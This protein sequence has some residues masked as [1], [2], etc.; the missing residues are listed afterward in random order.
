MNFRRER[1]PDQQHDI[2]ALQ[3]MNDQLLAKQAEAVRLKQLRVQR[4]L[5]KLAAIATDRRDGAPLIDESIHDFNLQRLPQ[6]RRHSAGYIRTARFTDGVLLRATTDN[7]FSDSLHTLVY[8]DGSSL[9]TYSREAINVDSQAVGASYMNIQTVNEIASV[10][11]IEFD[12]G[13]IHGTLEHEA[14]GGWQ[15]ALAVTALRR[16]RKQAQ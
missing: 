15:S 14:G 7:T 3:R 5:A 12:L 10:P 9:P 6:P 2:Q 8:Q 11:G 13:R 4:M 1:T 16:V